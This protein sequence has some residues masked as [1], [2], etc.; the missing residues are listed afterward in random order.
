MNSDPD[1]S[2]VVLMQ[3]HSSSGTSLYTIVLMLYTRYM[4]PGV[5][6]HDL[7]GHENNSALYI[8]YNKVTNSGTRIEVT[9][10]QIVPIWV[11]N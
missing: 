9:A 1:Y 2:A 3:M 8:E 6:K 4:K 10:G 7:N 11:I 5:Q